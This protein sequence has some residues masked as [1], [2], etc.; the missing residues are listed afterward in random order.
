[1]SFDRTGQAH[2]DAYGHGE[3][4]SVHQQFIIEPSFPPAPDTRQAIAAMVTAVNRRTDAHDAI[5]HLQDEKRDAWVAVNYRMPFLAAD[6]RHSHEQRI[7]T[8]YAAQIE[9]CRHG[10]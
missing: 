1:M 10:L 2:D 5:M 4:G 6:E 9:D 3:L 7:E 8:Y